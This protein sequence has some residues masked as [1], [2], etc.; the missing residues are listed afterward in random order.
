MDIQKT[1]LEGERDY[2]RAHLIADDDE[3]TIFH[4][5]VAIDEHLVETD[6]EDPN[7][8]GDTKAVLKCKLACLKHVRAALDERDG[9]SAWELLEIAD[10]HAEYGLNAHVTL[11]AIR[12]ARRKLKSAFPDPGFILEIARRHTASKEGAAFV[13]DAAS[14]FF[15]SIGVPVEVHDEDAAELQERVRG[16]LTRVLDFV[17]GTTNLLG[18]KV[19]GQP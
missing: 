12:A 17:L 10:E 11:E 4:H 14:R 13:L 1:F 16:E 6:L 3:R 5:S 15:D 2:A 18:E 19:D 8:H 9:K 7:V